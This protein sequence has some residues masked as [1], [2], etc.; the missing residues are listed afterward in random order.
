METTVTVLCCYKRDTAKFINLICGQQIW[1][2]NYTEKKMLWKLLLLYFKNN[3]KEKQ[4]H[5]ELNVK[6]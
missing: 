6:F 5:I 1:L 2:C 3:N 4:V